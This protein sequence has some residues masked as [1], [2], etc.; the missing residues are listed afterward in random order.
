MKENLG[1]YNSTVCSSGLG[2]FILIDK[3]I[4]VASE[5]K[6]SSKSAHISEYFF[7]T[8]QLT[9][10]EIAKEKLLSPGQFT[11]WKMLVSKSQGK[12]KQNGK[13]NN[14]KE[15]IICV[16]EGGLLVLLEKPYPIVGVM[17]K[18]VLWEHWL[19]DWGVPR[20]IQLFVDF[21][22]RPVLSWVYEVR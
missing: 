12:E 5:V 21:I 13:E 16:K 14:Y 18:K 11:V 9:E 17:E 22:C 8:K 6:T 4:S 15:N 7:A 20:I 2:E 19:E 10:F 3:T 1:I